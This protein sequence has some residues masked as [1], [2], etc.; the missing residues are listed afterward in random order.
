[1]SNPSNTAFPP[2]PPTD[3]DEPA[4]RAHLLQLLASPRENRIRDWQM[5]LRWPAQALEDDYQER[6]KQPFGHPW[7]KTETQAPT[8]PLPPPG[9][10]LGD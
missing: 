5:V 8:S 4:N 6:L 7:P 3:W 1:M 10:V 9:A 2:P